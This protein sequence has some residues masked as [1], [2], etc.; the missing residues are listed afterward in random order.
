MSWPWVP[1][2]RSIPWDIKAHF[3]IFPCKPAKSVSPLLRY[4]TN[5][6]THSS[7][8]P[9]FHFKFSWQV[10]QPLLTDISVSQSHCSW[11]Q[12]IYWEHTYTLINVTFQWSLHQRN[13]L[14]TLQEHFS[15][16]RCSP[17]EN[18]ESRGNTHQFSP[19][20]TDFVAVL[21]VENVFILCCFYLTASRMK[22]VIRRQRDLGW[23]GLGRVGDA[24][25][26]IPSK[27]PAR[28]GK[29]ETWQIKF[30]V[31][32]TGRNTRKNITLKTT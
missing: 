13:P 26:P 19:T 17:P 4:R 2:G 6:W 31:I 25:H 12:H 3:V 21:D 20:E 5:M 28:T 1:G 18:E 22:R 30:S 15:A 9:E 7:H 24:R 27:N 16:Q 11:R 14:L 10:V 8:T 29:W 32:H 23:W